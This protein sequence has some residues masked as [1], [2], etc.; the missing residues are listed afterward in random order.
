MYNPFPFALATF[1][2]MNSAMMVGVCLPT[3]CAPSL[4]ATILNDHFA[5]DKYHVQI[6]IWAGDCRFKTDNTTMFFSYQIFM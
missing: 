3:S 6:N 2:S 4:I 1:S 5:L